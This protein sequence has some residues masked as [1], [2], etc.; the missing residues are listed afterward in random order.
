VLFSNKF[1]HQFIQNHQLARIFDESLALL[2]V[3]EE[4][5]MLA[6]LPWNHHVV[7][8]WWNIAHDIPKAEEVAVHSQLQLAQRHKD[9]Q[10]CLF[11]QAELQVLL[12]ASLE[13]GVNDLV[14]VLSDLALVLQT[15]FLRS[16]IVFEALLDA[17][18][19]VLLIEQ[20]GHDEVEQRPQLLEIVVERCSGEQQSEGGPE[21][22]EA[23]E[24][25]GLVVLQFVRLVDDH[26]LPLDPCQLVYAGLRSLVVDDDD[27]EFFGLQNLLQKCFPRLNVQNHQFDPR[28]GKPFL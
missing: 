1:G 27:V 6:D 12:D 2:Y 7:V 26:G 8:C 10:L 13:E 22:V 18:E 9:G 24:I 25:L 11:Q 4:V 21:V 16:L 23:D 17:L 20:P 14:E 3:F 28:T 5:G 15:V 19:N